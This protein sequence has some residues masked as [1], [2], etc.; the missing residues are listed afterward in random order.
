MDAR[1]A[2]EQVRRAF[3]FP[4]VEPEEDISYLTR[5]QVVARHLRPGDRVL[6]FGCGACFLAAV[7]Q[8]MG[9][10]CAGWDDLN[11]Y[12]HRQRDNFQRILDFVRWAGVDLHVAD[13]SR[14]PFERESFDMVMAHGVIEHL[15]DSPRRILNDLLELVRSGGYLF[16][17]VPSAVN[18]RK[19]IGVLLGRT[20][21]PPFDSYYWYPGTWR[22]HVREYTRDD[23]ARLARNL[24]LQTLELR[25]FHG[26]LSA[27]PRVARPVFRTVSLLFPG[28]RDSW[29]LV[30]RKPPGWH[31]RREPDAAQMRRYDPTA[32]NT[33]RG[34]AGSSAAAQ[35]EAPCGSATGPST[36][37]DRAA[38]PG[39]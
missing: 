39:R 38:R 26:M 35:L 16:I 10:S 27:I 7:L 30:A 19:R 11:D 24:G 34:R 31:P 21:Y 4:Q 5:V 13:H 9:F 20:N 28:W 25:S 37:Q 33:S 18:I 14:C 17:T 2:L 29:L 1:Q 23:L 32:G 6:D 36:A 3:P 22:G 8:R 15:H 12:W